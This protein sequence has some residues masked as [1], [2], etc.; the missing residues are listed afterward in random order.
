MLKKKKYLM[1][2]KNKN[3]NFVMKYKSFFFNK[4]NK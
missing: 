4:F 3:K 2:E 1:W